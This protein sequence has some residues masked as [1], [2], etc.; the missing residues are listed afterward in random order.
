MRSASSRADLET[1]IGNPCRVGI[2]TGSYTLTRASWRLQKTPH[3]PRRLPS[4]ATK[5]A[6]DLQKALK[7][8][9]ALYFLRDNFSHLPGVVT[10]QLINFAGEPTRVQRVQ[11]RLD[12]REV[13]LTFK[14]NE[15]VPFFSDCYET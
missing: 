6:R 7:Q 13:A 11:H 12:G 3:P 9:D 8:A 14:H 15:I 5:R 10:A 1:K 4:P 2:C